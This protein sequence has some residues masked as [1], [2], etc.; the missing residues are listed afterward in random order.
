MDCC[1]PPGGGGPIKRTTFSDMWQKAAGP[2]GIATGEG[3][4]LLRHHYASV[5][6]ANGESVKTVQDRLGHTS[7]TMTLDIYGHL[8][9]EDEDRTR[10]AVDSTLGKAVAHADAHAGGS[11]QLNMQATSRF[12]GEPACRRDSVDPSRGRVAIHLSGLPGG[13]ARKEHRAGNPSPCSTLL[14]VGFTEPAGSPRPLVRSYRTVSP[15]PV[16]RTRRCHR[17]SV[18]CGTFLQVTPTGR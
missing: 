1:S 9:P 11:A 6:I 14:R 8:F 7:A 5:L 3:Y 15:L 16:R 18:F 12:D 2:L 13:G 17:R 4:H 10:V